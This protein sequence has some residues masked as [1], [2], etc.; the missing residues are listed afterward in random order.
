MRLPRAA[1]W[2]EAKAL[3]RPLADDVLKIVSA[4]PTRSVFQ[5]TGVNAAAPRM[6]DDVGHRMRARGIASRSPDDLMRSYPARVHRFGFNGK[7]RV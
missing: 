1:P 7:I 6:A 4:A 2:D 5:E 3:P